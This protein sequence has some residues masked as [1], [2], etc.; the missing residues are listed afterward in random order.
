MV[1]VI[2]EAADLVHLIHASSS[3]VVQ[4]QFQSHLGKKSWKFLELYEILK[5][6]WIVSTGSLFGFQFQ[7]HFMQDL[8]WWGW[9]SLILCSP[10]RGTK[11]KHNSDILG[12]HEHYLS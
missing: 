4:I 12:C 2:H 6:N 3:S 7:F 11:P 1:D 9:Y 8:I 5:W 10:S